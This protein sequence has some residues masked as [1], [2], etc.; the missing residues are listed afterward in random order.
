[1]A[2]VSGSV[3]PSALNWRGTMGSLACDLNRD[4]VGT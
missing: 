2:E 1:M 4:Q 3:C